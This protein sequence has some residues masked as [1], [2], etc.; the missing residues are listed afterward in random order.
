ML[1][2]GPFRVP[3]RLAYAFAIA[4]V[5]VLGVIVLV[6]SL[7]SN[8]SRSV[9]APVASARPIPSAAPAPRPASPS[10]P[11]KDTKLLE[12]ASAGD[13]AALAELLAIPADQRTAA[14]A[15]AVVKG[16]QAKEQKE[17]AELLQKIRRDP[18][19]L[20]QRRIQKQLVRAARDPVTGAATLRGLAAVDAPESADLLYKVWTGTRAKTP[21]TELARSLVHSKAVERRASPALAV[22]LALRKEVSCKAMKRT[23]KRAIKVGDRRSLMPL[24]KLMKKRGCGA[25]KAHDCWSCLR[26][27]DTLKRAV[28]AARGR[29]PPL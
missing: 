1:A 25:H 9:K 11:K 19:Q 14:Q 10:R 15:L 18:K 29:R 4:A 20:K 22:A 8:R 16:Q 2:L 12:R 26:H 28:I 17:Q 6:L 3:L 27:D 5:L 24:A 13:Q 21:M 23:V 7:S